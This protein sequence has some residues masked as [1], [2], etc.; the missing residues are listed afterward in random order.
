[1][2]FQ[3]NAVPL[4]TVEKRKKRKKTHKKTRKRP[5]EAKTTE[6]RSVL[7]QAIRGRNNK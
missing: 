2:D 6:N 7:A 3:I 4:K 5:D 1:M